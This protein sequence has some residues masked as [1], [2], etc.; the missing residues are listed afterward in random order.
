MTQP[1]LMILS[2]VNTH[3]CTR[4]PTCFSVPLHPLREGRSSAQSNCNLPI[5]TGELWCSHMQ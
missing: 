4:T 2:L 3:A 5:K 1:P